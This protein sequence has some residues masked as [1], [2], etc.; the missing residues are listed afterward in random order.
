MQPQ[1]G[2]LIS[3]RGGVAQVKFE[4]QPPPIHQLLK[5]KE[6]DLLFEVVEKKS[7]EIVTAIKLSNIKKIKQNEKIIA[8]E[9]KVGVNIDKEI[10]GRMFDLLGKPIDNRP[11]EG[12]EFI[13]FFN[14]RYDEKGENQF[15]KD[16][17][18]NEIIETG[19][20]IIDLLLPLRFGDKIGMFGG[21]G[22]GK[23]VLVTELMHNIALKKKGH[24]VFAGIGER[25]REGNDLYRT[26]KDLG[27]L[28]NMALYFGEMDKPAGARV[29]VG[30]AAATAAKYLCKQ[31]DEDI[32]LFIDN[33]FRYAMAGMEVGAVLDKVP[34]ELGYQATLQKDMATLQE[35][36][37]GIGDKTITSIQAVYVPADDLTDPAVAATSSH[38]DASLVLSRNIA[39]KGIYPAVDKLKSRATGL[40]EEIVSKRHF[41]IASGVKKVFQK[42]QELS[43]II[44]VLG[45]E[46]LSQSDRITAKRAERLERF[47]TQPLHVTEA[48][49]DKEGKYV[50]IKETLK[51]CEKILNGK[52]DNTE[53]EKLYM[54]GSINEIE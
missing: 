30:L 54:I 24:S 38:L 37:S 48:F 44:N 43:H 6:N 12:Q 4:S 51:G 27:V 32:F 33:I 9:K 35:K 5:S 40:D 13:P 21:A 53:L 18:E 22:V 10:L 52:F 50:P 29:R 31:Y 19:I 36:I 45:I 42:Y 1:A 26:L 14:N 23:T 11:Y 47:L 20:K 8:T 41:E 49:Q 3:Y 15:K 16:K 34:S 46:E 17:R 25:I 39:E 28:Q 7:P 2:K